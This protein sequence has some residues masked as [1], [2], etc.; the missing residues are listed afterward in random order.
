[1]NEALDIIHRKGFKVAVTVRPFVSTFSKTYKEGLEVAVTGYKLREKGAWIVQPYSEG[2]PAL[3][4]F[5]GEHSLAMADLTCTNV[6]DWMSQRLAQMVKRYDLDGV[7]L[8]S[9]TTD[10]LPHYYVTH[11]PMP[12]PSVLD[13]LWMETVRRTTNVISVNAASRMPRLPTFTAVPWL[14]ATWDGLATLLPLVLTLSMSGY[15]FLIPP[16]IGGFVSSASSN[17]E[18][19]LYI[20]WLQINTFL[21]VVQF[22]TLPSVYDNQ[23]ESMASN[24]THL[25]QSTVLPLLHRY[26]GDSV[27]SGLPIIRPLWMLD[28]LDKHAIDVLDEFCVGEE[29]LIAPILEH[30]K[31]ER[32][33]YL[34]KGV[35]KDGIDGSLRKGGRW[36]HHHKAKLY[37]IAYF[38]RMPDGTRW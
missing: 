17:P 23:V 3:T 12:D 28:P 8:E 16:P 26:G 10:H 20:R 5:N 37:Q 29:L 38:V 11:T 13:R 30:H 27:I 15:P 18:R 7:F 25:R 34:P 35:W 9:A 31:R 22:T 24:L 32:E 19:E 1:M 33:V 6:S 2:S 36:I 14:P 4:S 21:P